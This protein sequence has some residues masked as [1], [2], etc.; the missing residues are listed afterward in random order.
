MALQAWLPKERWHEINHMLVGFGQTICLPVGRKCGECT[1]SERGLCPSAVVE[2]KKAVKKAKREEVRDGMEEEVMEE[3][4]VVK[5]EGV[6]LGRVETEVVK[7]N[8]TVKEEGT[9]AQAAG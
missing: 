7:E 9:T 1:L 6:T 3:V 4:N 8:K 5:E 2:R